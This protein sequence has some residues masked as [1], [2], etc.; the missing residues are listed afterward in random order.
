MKNEQDC[1][2]RL[3]R[4]GVSWDN[5]RALR[6][7]AMQLHRW[8]EMECGTE[9]GHVERDEKT[10]K[11]AWYMERN[12]QRMPC[13]DM[14]K[15]ALKRLASIMAEYPALASYVQ[16]DPRSAALYIVRPGDV[17]AGAE[18]DSYYNNGIAV[19]R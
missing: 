8:H 4:A 11:T 13:R 1:I 3:T 10:G 16:G 18:V 15:G 7:I 14:E 12:G 6:R 5:A 17:P 2:H 9:S 19:Y